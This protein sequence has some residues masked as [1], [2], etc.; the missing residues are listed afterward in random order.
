MEEHDRNKLLT[1]T[2]ILDIFLILIIFLY[3]LNMFDTFWVSIVLLS[4][5]FFYYNVINYNRKIL[6]ILHYL[7]FILPTLSLLSDNIFIKTISL[8]LIVLI[9]IL[10]IK[11]NR[12]ILNESDSKFGYADELNYYVIFLTCLL[13]LNISYKIK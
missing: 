11:E 4:H 3:K 12:C 6:E 2:G 1:I 10:W 13:S 9:Q 8:C 7:I 5:V